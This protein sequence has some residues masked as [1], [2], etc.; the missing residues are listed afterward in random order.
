MIY[1]HQQKAID[2]VTKICKEWFTAPLAKRSSFKMISVDGE[3]QSGKTGFM[4]GTIPKLDMIDPNKSILAA[5]TYPLIEQQMQFYSDIT[6]AGLPASIVSLTTI[7][8]QLEDMKRGLKQKLKDTFHKTTFF[9]IDESEY[10]IGE[11]STLDDL[12]NFLV[13]EFPD[14]RFCFIFVGATNYSI[15]ALSTQFTIDYSQVVL[16]DGDGYRGI[17]WFYEN[18]CII[19]YT[20][21]MRNHKTLDPKSST[22]LDEALEEHTNGLYLI[23]AKQ[24]KDSDFKYQYLTKK[25]GHEIQNGDLVIERIDSH[26]CN[27]SSPS[28]FNNISQGLNKLSMDSRTKRVIIIVIGGLSAGYRLMNK[29]NIRYIRDYRGKIASTIQGF[30]GRSCGYHKNEPTLIV[31]EFM[32]EEHLKFRESVLKGKEWYVPVDASTHMSGGKETDTFIPAKIIDVT[33]PV[34]GS[35]SNVNQNPG[36]YQRI[37]KVVKNYIDNLNL[38]WDSTTDNVSNMFSVGRRKE[39]FDGQYD[40]RPRVNFKEVLPLTE[41]QNPNYSAFGW[42]QNKQKPITILW[43]YH[44]VNDVWKLEIKLVYKDGTPIVS[45]KKVVKST[46]MYNNGHYVS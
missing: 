9:V 22:L 16:E 1:K 13:S 6:G 3:P 12:I 23:R 25:Y 35:I 27:P 21:E 20:K 32:V 40:Y 30:L 19:D 2:S 17:K 28:M 15:K 44:K 31:P 4:Q 24:I 38:I 41:K 11:D 37:E 8:P 36:G 34:L 10:R 7:R 43:N 29:E 46:S 45:K 5:Q 18:N 42:Y 14:K 33:K 39:H 26:E